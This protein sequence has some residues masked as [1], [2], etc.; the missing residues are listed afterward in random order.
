[1]QPEWTVGKLLAWAAPYLEKHT[2]SSPRLSA[3]LMLAKAL[4]CDRLQ[5]YLNY[6]RPLLPPELAAFKQLLLRRRGHEPMAYITGCREF[7]G[8]NLVVGAGVLIPR[9]ETEHLVETALSLLAEC[10]NAAPR[11][12]DLC[13]GSGAVAL[14]LAANY[15][16]AQIMASDI[17]E[18]ALQYARLN[19]ENLGLTIDFQK[20]SLWQPWA[21]RGLFFDLITA[22]PPYVSQREWQGLS[23]EVRDFEPSQALLAGEQGL[24][25][26][27]DIIYGARA[28]LRPF[29]SLLIEIGAGQARAAS[30]L[31]LQAGIYHKIY[32]VSDLAGHD[33]IL[34]CQRSDYG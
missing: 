13:T 21:I 34:V 33:R 2:V 17:S 7:Y 1:M 12:L 6:D 18:P 28:F 25:I 22:N 15:P 11:V 8:L 23:P 10:E 9:P 14:A 5:L 4:N 3:E 27:S 16:N 26:I 19:A 32:T 29:A 20:G 24:D 31:A 30:K